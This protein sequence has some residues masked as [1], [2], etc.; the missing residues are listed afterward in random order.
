[1]KKQMLMAIVVA[2]VGCDIGNDSEAPLFNQWECICQMQ[3]DGEQL[4]E[5]I[6][7]TEC[8]EATDDETSIVMDISEKCYNGL[9]EAGC[10][11]DNSTSCLCICENYGETCKE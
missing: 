2:L 3:C 1:M 7:G 5:S 10:N 11:D 9:V 8:A 4:S 6:D